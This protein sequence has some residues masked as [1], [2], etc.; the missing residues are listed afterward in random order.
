MN[1]NDYPALYCATNKASIDAQKQYLNFIRAYSVLLT[2][3]AGLGVYGI[4]EKVSAIFAALLVIGSI[5]LSVIMLLRRGEDTWYRA[6]SVAESVKTSSWRFMMRC[7]PYIDSNDVREVKSR[8]RSRLKNIL[9]E[10]KDLAE[11]LGGTVSEQEQITERMC[12][13]RALTWQQRVSFYRTHRIDEQRTWYA[14][15][16]AWNR[17]SGKLWFSILIG[18]QAIA[19][20]FLVLRVAY[21]S[22]GYWPADI[23]VVAAGSSLTWMQ[24]KRFRELSAAYGLTAHE[25][26][27]IRGELEQIDSEVK[28]SEFIADSEN[29]FSREHTQWLARKDS[30]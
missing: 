4:D 27:V 25:V 16:S 17:K 28:L 19:V 10:H 18:C 11:H 30:V 21:P 2:F 23:F 29:A 1:D 15:K 3:A 20:L 7:E 12:E 22:W 9:N 6:R 13:V 5:F 8:F 24:V 14:N 26:G